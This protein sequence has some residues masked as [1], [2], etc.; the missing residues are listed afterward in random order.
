[1]GD[2]SQKQMENLDKTVS[3]LQEHIPSLI[4]GLKN[5][6]TEN[7]EQGKEFISHL[8]KAGL[9]HQKQ[10][11]QSFIELSQNIKSEFEVLFQN[12]TQNMSKT[13]NSYSEKLRNL[14]TSISDMNENILKQTEESRVQYQNHL[15]E[16]GK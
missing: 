6:Q 7:E 12:I 14:M 15:D 11:N 5:S 8:N 9:D 3:T 1:M 2:F 13:L 16:N 10:M 4:S